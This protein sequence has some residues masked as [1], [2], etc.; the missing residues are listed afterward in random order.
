MMFNEPFAAFTSAVLILLSAIDLRAVALAGATG[1]TECY[2]DA[3]TGTVTV[4][5]FSSDC[6]ISLITI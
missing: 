5:L 1:G 4:E 2:F 6:G 3:G